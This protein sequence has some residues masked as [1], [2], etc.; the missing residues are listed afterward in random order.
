MSK[1]YNLW[2]HNDPFFIGGGESINGI[3]SGHQIQV[4]KS[5]MKSLS[6]THATG[7]KEYKWDSSL[8]PDELDS[9]TLMP[10]TEDSKECSKV[11]GRKAYSWDFHLAPSAEVPLPSCP[12][13]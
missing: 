4:L 12:S 5:L 2:A 1:A 6:Q 9:F 8:P 10:S 11:P 13:I 7:G 3:L